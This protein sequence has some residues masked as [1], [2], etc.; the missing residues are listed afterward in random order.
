V[1]ERVATDLAKTEIRAPF[2]GHVVS[3]FVEVGNWV[4]IGGEV[5]E[6]ADQSQVLIR[7][8][9][10]EAAIPYAT[11][12]S[13]SAAWVDALQRRVE[14]KV[15]HVIPQADRAARTFPVEINVPNS[16]FAL[17]AGMFCRATI[18]AGPTT[19]VPVVPK[20][21]LIESGGQI[22]VAL[23][24]PGEKGDMAMPVPVSL[25]VDDGDWIAISSGNVQA[26]GR[27]A[28]YGNERLVF[29]QPVTVVES[30]EKVDRHRQAGHPQALKQ[31]KPTSAASN[32]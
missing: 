3:R 14:G 16:D 25:G 22:Y 15:K 32:G 6:L 8:D 29:P 20:D 30:P 11:V 27:V 9:A 1:V 21:A 31:T 28:V 26:G 19:D 7:V 24:V 5:I 4:P 2:G 23:I 17:K 18:L 13:A 12:G 10:P